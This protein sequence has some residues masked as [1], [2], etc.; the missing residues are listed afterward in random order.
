MVRKSIVAVVLIAVVSVVAAQAASMVIATIGVGALPFDMVLSSSGDKGYVTNFW[1]RSVSVIDTVSLTV[2]ATVGTK[3]FDSDDGHPALAIMPDDSKVY[4]ANVRPFPQPGVVSV[5]DTTSNTLVKEIDVGT[6]PRALAVTPNG[7]KLYVLNQGAN[8]VS[9]VSTATDTVTATIPVA[10]S[11]ST[12]VIAPDGS[13]VFFANVSNTLAGQV[14]VINTISDTVVADVMT[15]PAFGGAPFELAMNASGTIL[16]TVNREAGT[17]SAINV[18]T[19]AVVAAIPVGYLPNGAA[20]TP[21]DGLLYV[22]NSGDSTVT[23]I[24]TATNAVL[25]TIAV[26]PG[27]PRGIA[28]TPDGSEVFVGDA[29]GGP[30]SV[31]ETATNTVTETVVVS[32]GIYD[33]LTSPDGARVYVVGAAVDTVD[34]I[35]RELTVALLVDIKPGSFPNS[36]DP[37]NRGV[38]PVAVFGSVGLDV[39]LI[40]VAELRF[41][42]DGAPPAHS[43]HYED[44][45]DDGFADLVAHFRTQLTGISAGDVEA[46]ISGLTTDGRSVEGCDSIRTVGR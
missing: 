16:Y 5:I 19:R 2:A 17:V 44:V 11:P 1:D 15:T 41:G 28:V 18:A 22:T 45:N 14:S 30:V 6:N 9:V 10:L 32:G 3:A 46:C 12:L 26:A 34:V 29:G 21:D 24:D 36:I 8:S 42:P 31:I 25:T 4:V 13:E 38:I 20:I 35:E 43:G 27:L 37:N 33:V 7:L 39:H 40:D 23:V